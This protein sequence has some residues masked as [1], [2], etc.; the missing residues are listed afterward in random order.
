MEPKTL[1]LFKDESGQ[2]IASVTPAGL[3]VAWSS[4]N[5]DIAIVE[6]GTVTGLEPGTVTITGSIEY[7][8]VTYSDTVTVEVSPYALVRDYTSSSNWDNASYFESKQYFE[9]NRQTRLVYENEALE[10]VYDEVAPSTSTLFAD[11]K[12]SLEGLEL[13]ENKAYKLLLDFN[14]TA[15]AS[16]TL[17]V[18]CTGAAANML[19]GNNVDEVVTLEP[20][21]T[22]VIKELTYNASGTRAF[23]LQVKLNE[24]LPTGAISFTIKLVNT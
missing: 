1:Q 13:D 2:I 5:S 14:N 23:T 6:D 16:Y 21:S 20:G 19:K 4:S 7:E 11:I 9:T 12:T 10:L 3:A 17:Q 18:K 24:P 15:E 8:G 22:Q